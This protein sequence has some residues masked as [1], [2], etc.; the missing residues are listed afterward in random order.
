M[1]RTSTPSNP[2]NSFGSIM[3]GRNYEGDTSLRYRFGFNGK[4]KDNETYGDGNELDFGARIYDSRLGRFLSMDPLSRK[5]AH[6]SPYL[7]LDNNPLSFIDKGGDSTAYY[8]AKG[9][10]LFKSNDSRPDAIVII[11]DDKVFEFNKMLSQA[12]V[13]NKNP[14]NPKDNEGVDEFRKLGKV[15]ELSIFRDLYK[16]SMDESNLDKGTKSDNKTIYFVDAKTGKPLHNE[17]EMKLQDVNGKIVPLGKDKPGNF[18]SVVQDVGVPGTVAT[19]HSH[20]EINVS[21]YIKTVVGK[22]VSWALDKS[23]SGVSAGDKFSCK[24]QPGY[25]SIVVEKNTTYFYDSSNVAITFK[26]FK[27]APVAPK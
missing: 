11:S 8:T 27:N 15:Y 13:N 9:F 24:A 7:A 16:R 20:T 2:L 17:I 6:K 14:E 4:E 1:H 21:Y 5:F 26:N 22:A 25:L 10:L 12:I 23:Y 3:E 18:E 19:A